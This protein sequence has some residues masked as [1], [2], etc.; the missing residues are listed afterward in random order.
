MVYSV[1]SIYEQIQHSYNKCSLF[2]LN[3]EKTSTDCV[4]RHVPR[5]LATASRPN[6]ESV[7]I[8]FSVILRNLEREEESNG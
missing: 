8:S 5:A 6:G 4:T 3:D 1:H 2:L 7:W